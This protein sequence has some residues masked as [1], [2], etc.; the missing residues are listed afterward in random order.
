MS[1]LVLKYALDTYLFEEAKSVLPADIEANRDTLS[2]DEVIKLYITSNN[3]ALNKYFSALFL[4]KLEKESPKGLSY[5]KMLSYGEYLLQTAPELRES[6]IECCDSI[7]ITELNESKDENDVMA[8]CH[9]GISLKRLGKMDLIGMKIGLRDF[10]AFMWKKT[11]EVYKLNDS[12][13]ILDHLNSLHY[14]QEYLEFPDLEAL[15][16]INIHA[17]LDFIGENITNEF[18]SNEGN[19]DIQEAHKILNFLEMLES[20]D[21]D[22]DKDIKNMREK[23]NLIS[24]PNQDQSKTLKLTPFQHSNLYSIP[25]DEFS[26]TLTELPFN[27]NITEN[28]QM[29]IYKAKNYDNDVCAKYYKILKENT[30]TSQIFSEINI[31]SRLSEIANANNC[32]LKYYGSYLD[33]KKGIW[34]I[35]EYIPENLSTFFKKLKDQSI[36]LNEQ[37][38]ANIFLKLI[39][40]FKIMKDLGIFHRDIKPDNL[41]IDKFQNVKIID[42][43][44][45]LFKSH[46]YD[47]KTTSEYEIKGTKNY[48][49]PELLELIGKNIDSAI[50]NPEKSDVFSLGLVFLEFFKIKK[51]R[52]LNTVKKNE[53]LFRRISKVPYPWVRELLANMLNANPEKRRTFGEL[54]NYIDS[55]STRTMKH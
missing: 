34:M 8:W 54:L 7:L 20:K 55:K 27:S 48:I 43:N 49:A 3:V 30:D 15:V 26:I 44:I 18:E 6:I 29:A 21:K 11:N 28:F 47:N 42:F 32:F 24:P 31:Y 16:I 25:N 38:Y 39:S 13:K 45:S 41:L 52:G 22:Y 17:A 36:E 40:S 4:I 51:L 23:C 14:G 9:Q 53:R 10:I 50:F 19:M 33:S 46:N 37:V 12:Q 5:A 1:T 35:M 2:L